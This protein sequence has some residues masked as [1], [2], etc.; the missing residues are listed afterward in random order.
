[1]DYSTDFRDVLRHYDSNSQVVTFSYISNMP[2]GL[3]AILI[4]S[5]DQELF[6]SIHILFYF[7]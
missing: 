4:Y 2:S 3:R 6:L 1:M 7:V 5:M